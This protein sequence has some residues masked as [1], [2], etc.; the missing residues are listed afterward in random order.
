MQS[1]ADGYLLRLYMKPEDPNTPPK[2]SCE[3]AASA[4]IEVHPVAGEILSQQRPDSPIL[5][6]RGRTHYR[7]M[8]GPVETLAGD[9]RP[10][11][12]RKSETSELKKPVEHAR[13]EDDGTAR[14]DR[15][16]H[17]CAHTEGEFEGQDDADKE[18]A[19]ADGRRQQESWPAKLLDA[20][21]LG[22]EE[23][24]ARSIRLA[25]EEVKGESEGV[26]SFVDHTQRIVG[27]E[28]TPSTI[29]TANSTMVGVSP[30]ME[31]PV[32]SRPPSSAPTIA[33]SAIEPAA[34]TK[35]SM[36][37]LSSG[38][39]FLQALTKRPIP[40][41]YTTTRPDSTQ[42]PSLP[43]EILPD[44]LPTATRTHPNSSNAPSSPLGQITSTGTLPTPS[45]EHTIH[46]RP[47][48]TSVEDKTASK[49]LSATQAKPEN[50]EDFFS[51]YRADSRPQN[52]PTSP[53]D[54][55]P[56][57]FALDSRPIRAAP[58][59]RTAHE[60]KTLTLLSGSGSCGHI[61][62]P[63]RYRKDE[64]LKIGNAYRQKIFLA[65]LEKE[66]R[67]R[68]ILGMTEGVSV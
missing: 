9:E 57:N 45:G 52:A 29:A 61:Y 23:E 32:S 21:N 35:P 59:V 38:H 7:P 6:G 28:P 41:K 63:C 39:A 31:E 27:R 15:E 51:E 19:G 18:N 53:T 37:L 54:H 56:S 1:Q 3:E 25:E 30:T 55:L 17:S 66:G 60:I 68:I 65:L 36:P 20:T 67:G 48:S 40:P 62:R 26:R 50:H 8:D 2:A 34:G 5:R 64:L 46:I 11:L 47:P 22:S 13:A 16:K 33:E 43:T 24:V 42:A 44:E 58:P 10:A 12:V 4:Q 14:K 49:Q